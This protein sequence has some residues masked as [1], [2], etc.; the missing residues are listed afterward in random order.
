LLGT[1]FDLVT[2]IQVGDVPPGRFAHLAALLGGH[3]QFRSALLELDRVHAGMP[4]G[5]HQLPGNLD[6][7]IMIDANFRNYIGRI[8][9]A[10]PTISDFDCFCHSF[11][12]QQSTKKT[13]LKFVYNAIVY[14]LRS[15]DY[16]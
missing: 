12:P 11:A 5:I 14:R 10:D 15:D 4:G 2:V 3:A 6:V 8:S 16:D 13:E 9:I 1:K 7:T